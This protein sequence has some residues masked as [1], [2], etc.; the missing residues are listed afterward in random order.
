MLLSSAGEHLP[1]GLKLVLEYI[2]SFF[3]GHG[4]AGQAREMRLP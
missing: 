2:S 3:D 1:P 4:V